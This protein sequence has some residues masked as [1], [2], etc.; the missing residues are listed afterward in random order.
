ME[1]SEKL[2]VSESDFRSPFYLTH[3]YKLFNFLK[4]TLL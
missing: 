1:G 2:R 3:F 4:G